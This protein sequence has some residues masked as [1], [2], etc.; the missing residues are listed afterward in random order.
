MRN[1]EKWGSKIGFIFAASGSAV[2]IGNIWKY[3]HRAG[4]NGGAAFTVVYLLCFLVIGLTI[5]A[6]GTSLPE[7]AVTVGAGLRG[8]GGVAVGNVLGSNV[9]NIMGI[10]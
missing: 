6:L 2:G 9:M 1:R 10:I 8:Q 3:P 4:Q 7:L 5:V